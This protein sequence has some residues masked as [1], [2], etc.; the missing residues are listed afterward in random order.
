MSARLRFSS[1]AKA[2][3]KREGIEPAADDRRRVGNH[4]D[5]SVEAAEHLRQGAPS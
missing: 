2:F 3:E 4:P 5:D 1:S